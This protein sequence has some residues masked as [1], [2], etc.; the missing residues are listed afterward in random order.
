MVHEARLELASLAALEPKTVMALATCRF[1][2]GFAIEA[3]SLGSAGMVVPAI[4]DPEQPIEGLQWSKVQFLEGPSEATIARE[5]GACRVP[6]AVHDPRLAAAGRQGD[7]HE[8][9]AQVV[10]P[11]AEARAGRLEQLGALHA[12][13]AEGEAEAFGEAIHVHLVAV[14]LDEDR[15][16]RL[17][18]GGVLGLPLVAPRAKDAGHVG[19]DRPRAWVVRL[20]LVEAHAPDVEVQVAPREPGGLRRPHALTG[21]ETEQHALAQE[22]VGGRDE[23]GLVCGVEGGLRLLGAFLGEPA[24]R[25]GRRVAELEGVHREPKDALHELGDVAA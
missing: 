11:K 14:R 10:C 7:G 15:G 22:H 1:P 25:D 9:A 16:A 21:Q 24:A 3:A 6:R 18:E 8:G 23:P 5:H 12:S 13:G 19:G 17:D 2:R 4:L 20:V